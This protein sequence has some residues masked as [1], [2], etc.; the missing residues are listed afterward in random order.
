[1]EKIVSKLLKDEESFERAAKTL[2]FHADLN[3]D[4]IVDYNE[5]RHE[6]YKMSDDLNLAKPNDDEIKKIIK[7][8]D[9]NRNKKIEYNEFKVFLKDLFTE[10]SNS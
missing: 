4:H 5:F 7:R 9:A 10:I 2:Y 1:M 6:I 8:V 3:G